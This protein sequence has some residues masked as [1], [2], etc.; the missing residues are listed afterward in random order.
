MDRRRATLGTDAPGGM[1]PESDSLA[2]HPPRIEPIRAPAAPAGT[3]GRRRACDYRRFVV[4]RARE[5]QGTTRGPSDFEDMPSAGVRFRGHAFAK[6]G[7]TSTCSRAVA[8]RRRRASARPAARRIA[9]RG[10]SLGS[11][12]RRAMPRGVKKS[13]LP[14]KVCPTCGRPFAWRKK[15]AKVWDEVRYCSNRCRRGARADAADSAPR[16]DPQ[17][18]ASPTSV[19]GG[20][21]GV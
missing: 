5:G 18:H 4:G 16:E 13:D 1:P 10:A 17:P 15:W 9:G 2:G 14:T 12:R 19:P 6:Q 8:G 7:S 3:S 11:D 21:H 20:S